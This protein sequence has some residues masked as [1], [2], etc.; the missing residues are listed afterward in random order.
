MKLKRI[1]V[2]ADESDA[3]RSAV[4]AGVDFGA[5]AGARV[6]VMRTVAA[7]SVPALAG[8]G[9]RESAHG[10]ADDLMAEAERLSRWLGPELSGDGPAVD[11]AITQGVPGIEICR[12]T[13]AVDAD[14]LV[15]GRTARSTATRLLIGD[16]ADAVARRSRTPCL[17]IPPGSPP[18]R[19]ILVALDGTDRGLTVV[20]TAARI[21][22]AI[23]AELQTVTVEPL[24]PGEPA[25][26]VT[27]PPLARSMRLQQRLRELLGHDHGGT[28]LHI[29]RGGTVEQVLAAVEPAG[30]DTLAVGYHRGGPAGI[31]EAGS[32][33]RRLMHGAPG[34]V[35]TIPL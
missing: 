8:V 2:A 15:L 16:T 7:F 10:G 33:G 28:R 24:V 29:R 23:G 13:E 9:Q 26:G 34:A 5:R 22:E 1:V 6:T 27:T 32:T 35:L 31:I 21:A 12:Y 14:L 4:R 3:G 30:A 19:R 17:F 18:V 25:E 11:V 20:V